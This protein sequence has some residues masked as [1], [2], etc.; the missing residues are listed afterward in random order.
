MGKRGGYRR[1][2]TM[3]ALKFEDPQFEGLEVMAKSLPLGEFLAMQRLQ[4]R[5]AEDTDA[6]EQVL[7]KLAS[8]LVSWNLEDEQGQPVP[9]QYA[10]CRVSGKPVAPG[11]R[12]PECAST[13]EDEQP[14]DY[15]GI[16]GQEL[17]FVLTIF[18][19][20]MGAVASVPNLSPNDSNGGGTSLEQSLPM[21]VS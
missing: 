8:V 6:A 13:A 2:P 12:C 19:A 21:E 10:V 1:E 3:Y 16:A 7:R 20:W 9:I 17:P 14:C 5:A 11:K 18:Q 4:G 15:T